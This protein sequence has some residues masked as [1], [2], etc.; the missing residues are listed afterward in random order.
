MNKIMCLSLGLLMTSTMGVHADTSDAPNTA[1][2][3][4][5][6]ERL[7]ST[8][9]G[10][11]NLP[12][13]ITLENKMFES[14]PDL[15]I[16]ASF[17]YW[18]VSEEGLDLANSSMFVANG[19][20]TGY[21]SS[22]T[23]NSTSLFQ[24]SGYTPGFKVGIGGSFGDWT[25]SALY[26]WVRQHN[27][28]SKE[29]PTA[30]PDLGTSIWIPD[31]WFQ[32]T[33]ALGQA[34][35]A[36]HLSSRWKVS[37]DLADLT[38]GRPYYQGKELTLSPFFGLRAAWIRQKLNLNIAIPSTALP[39]SSTL[40]TYSNNSSHSWAL[41]P[42]VGCEADWLLPM[43]FRLEGSF[44]GS[45]LFTQ[46]THVN[47]TEKVA[48]FGSTPSTLGTSLSDYNCLRPVAE[49]GAGLGWGMYLCKQMYHIDFAASYDFMYFWSQ[50]MMKKIM[51]QTLS[52]AS[53][54]GDLELHGL[55]ITARFDF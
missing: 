49:L 11:Y 41:G 21:L 8:A 10:S 19:P 2:I 22:A 29:A 52:G 17:T 5:P 26:T 50:N 37:M 4:K 45:I 35:V 47:H 28:T 46:Y 7:T 18:N 13:R 44:A 1:D 15:F 53:S 40:N 55:T 23:S 6:G 33:T 31:D 30:S 51:D 43:G 32:Q 3:S 24:N 54:N 16:D 20:H 36:T 27:F 39:T 48:S 9:P 12:A 42:R 34:I 14:I 38:L 25:V